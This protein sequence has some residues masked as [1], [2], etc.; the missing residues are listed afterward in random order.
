MMPPRSTQGYAVVQTFDAKVDSAGSFGISRHWPSI[1]NF[2]PWYGLS[3]AFSLRGLR[4][5]AARD[6]TFDVRVTIDGHEKPRALAFAA[7]DRRLHALAF[8]RFALL[9]A[10][11]GLVVRRRRWRRCATGDAHEDAEPTRHDHQAVHS[12]LRLQVRPGCCEWRPL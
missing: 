5:V 11:A 7:V 4:D 6:H 10:G 2:H 12:R 1:A 8:V 3:M 9:G